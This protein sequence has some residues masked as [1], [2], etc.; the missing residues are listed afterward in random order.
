MT[1]QLLLDLK[2]LGLKEAKMYA[3]INHFWWSCLN[4]QEIKGL[5][6]QQL[7]CQV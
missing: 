5:C 4:I 6:S 7:L 3:I 1:T 2:K